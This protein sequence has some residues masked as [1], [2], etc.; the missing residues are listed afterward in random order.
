MMQT[1]EKWF[2]LESPRDLRTI[3]SDH[4]TDAPVPL[5]PADKCTRAPRSQALFKVSDH[6]KYGPELVCERF[7][8]HGWSD[9]RQLS[10]LIK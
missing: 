5:V 6:S 1:N 9:E 3:R 4:F 7:R 8:S 10:I 2:L